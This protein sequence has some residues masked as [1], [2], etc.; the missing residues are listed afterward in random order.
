MTFHIRINDFRFHQ[1]NYLA[2][3]DL[4]RFLK[5]HQF[6]SCRL[7]FD[8]NQYNVSK[9]VFS[10]FFIEPE[11]DPSRLFHSTTRHTKSK[12]FNFFNNSTILVIGHDQVKN[13][14]VKLKVGPNE[15]TN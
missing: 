10:N 4:V 2:A 6:N 14:K 8:F 9:I 11:F 3:A 7:N 15:S 13:L 1:K 5:S 12:L